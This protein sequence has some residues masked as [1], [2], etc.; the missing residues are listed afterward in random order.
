MKTLTFRSRVDAW[1][2]AVMLGV[3]V[4]DINLEG[5]PAFVRSPYGIVTTTAV[6]SI[7]FP[8]PAVPRGPVAPCQNAD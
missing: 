1:L 2:L 8:P 6:P 5:A 7:N 4:A 3:P